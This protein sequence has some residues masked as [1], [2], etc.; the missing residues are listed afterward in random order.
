MVALVSVIGVGGIA[1]G[2]GGLGVRDVVDEDQRE[3]VR[4]RVSRATRRDE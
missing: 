1:G 3:T 2:E 4:A